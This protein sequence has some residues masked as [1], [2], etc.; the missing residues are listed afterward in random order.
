MIPKNMV[1]WLLYIYDVIQSHY[2]FLKT[3]V[4]RG[5]YIYI[6]LF[7]Q[8]YSAVLAVNSSSTVEF[9]EPKMNTITNS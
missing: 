5:G 4:N 7:N 2:N 8:N 6:Y 3:V 1:I 9:C